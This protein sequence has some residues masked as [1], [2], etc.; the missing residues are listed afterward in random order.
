MKH[1]TKYSSLST[2]DYKIWV[3]WSKEDKCYIG[4]V[5]PDVT[6]YEGQI[7]GHGDSKAKAHK[8]IIEVLQL[9]LACLRED[10]NLASNP[11]DTRNTP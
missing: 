3:K 9:I 7:L 11:T 4:G 10:M 6:G 1:K 2:M 8:C 5:I